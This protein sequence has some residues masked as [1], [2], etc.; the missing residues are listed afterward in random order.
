QRGGEESALRG[1]AVLVHV[2]DEVDRAAL[3]GCGEHPG[4]CVAQPFVLVGDAEAH[5]LQAA[6]AE[7]AEQ[8]GPEGLRLGLAQVEGDHLAPAALVY[9]VG[10]H[11][12]LRAD[13]TAVSDLHLF[14]VQPEIGV[15]ALERP[16]P[17]RLDQLVE[18]AT[19]SRDAVLAHSLDTEL[20]DQ[21]VDLPGRDAVDVRL[22]HDRDD[23]LLR[24]SP[25]LQEGREVRRTRTLARDL[26]PT[27]AELPS[28]GR[29]GRRYTTSTAVTAP[30]GS[31][32]SLSVRLSIRERAAEDLDDDWPEV[33]KAVRRA[34]GQG[35]G[36]G[37]SVNGRFRNAT[38]A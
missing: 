22:E 7:V 11:E 38:D 5:T 31:S 3:P 12:R 26:E 18:R 1:P 20:L 4:D 24:A 10:D 28:R 35:F 27:V 34:R 19:E 37:E 15:V 8:L 6:A 16:L 17:E 36:Q 21:P 23:R 33:L 13:V 25:R 9:R 32:R 2:A 14:R 29:R 30:G